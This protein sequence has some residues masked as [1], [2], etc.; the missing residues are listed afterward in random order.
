M[1]RTTT[2][3]TTTMTMQTTTSTNTTMTMKTTTL[4]ARNT[5]TIPPKAKKNL[6]VKSSTLLKVMMM[7]QTE[8]P[9]ACFHS[10]IWGRSSKHAHWIKK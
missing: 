2:S 3:R 9:N 10:H 6:L 1:V 4:I 8:E 7:V 5:M